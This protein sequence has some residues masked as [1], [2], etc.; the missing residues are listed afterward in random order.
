MYIL[1][2]AGCVFV[3]L[4]LVFHNVVHIPRI[5]NLKNIIL[6]STDR[7]LFCYP[8]RLLTSI[9]SRFNIMRGSETNFKNYTFKQFWLTKR[10]RREI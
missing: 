10:F 5:N 6:Q 7:R 3:A 9:I 1:C 4:G 2:P 8:V